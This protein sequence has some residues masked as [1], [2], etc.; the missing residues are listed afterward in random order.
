MDKYEL[1]FEELCKLMDAQMQLAQFL[2]RNSFNEVT[3]EF[4]ATAKKASGE[5]Y[6][7]IAKLCEPRQEDAAKEK[8]NG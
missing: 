8:S 3:P 7:V 5:A 2:L 1:T 6:M 4:L